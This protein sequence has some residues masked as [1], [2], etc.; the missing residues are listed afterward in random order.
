MNKKNNGSGFNSQKYGDLKQGSEENRI[1]NPIEKNA[2]NV[3]SDRTNNRESNTNQ[4]SNRQAEYTQDEVSS[5]EIMYENTRGQQNLN[6]RTDMQRNNLQR[7]S[8][9]RS[10]DRGSFD[11]SGERSNDRSN[12]RNVD[13]NI[14]RNN[15]G[16]GGQRNNT[17]S[18]NSHSSNT[19]YSN[20]YDQRNQTQALKYGLKTSASVQNSY[21]T[22]QTYMPEEYNHFFQRQ[23]ERLEQI[24][25][26]KVDKDKVH[27]LPL[28]GIGE[29][30]MNSLLYHYLGRWIMIDCGNSFDKLYKNVSHVVIPSVSFVEERLEQFDG[31]FLTHGHEDHIG[32]LPYI[33]E[34]LGCPI[35]GTKFTITLVRRK[36]EERGLPTENLIEVEVG[37]WY[38]FG[39]FEMKW[40]LS[41]HSIPGCCMIALRTPYGSILHTGDWKI[42]DAP[43]INELTDF[44]SIKKLASE[45]LYAVVSDSTN[46]MEAGFNPTEEEVSKSLIKLMTSIQK[47]RIFVTF[48]STNIARLY[49]CIEAG[50]ISGR[51]VGILGRAL[52]RSYEVA[53][54]CGYLKHQDHV[55]FEG[56]E[57]IAPDQVIIA[58]SGSQGEER[59]A[60][61][62]VSLGLHKLIHI[63][64][65]DTVIFSCR[66]IPT[67][68]KEMVAL[69][70]A[71]V[72]RGAKVIT[73]KDALIHSSGH[74]RQKEFE[75]FYNLIKENAVRKVW[76][77]PC[78]GTSMFLERHAAFARERGFLTFS[79]KESFH[80]GKIYQVTQEVKFIDEID[81]E[82]YFLDGNKVVSTDSPII[83]ERQI[84]QEGM[85]S[86]VAVI[87]NGRRLS[88]MHINSYGVD[89]DRAWIESEVK[90]MLVNIFQDLD[91]RTM[92]L[93]KMI[94]NKIANFTRF[95][96]DKQIYVDLHIINESAFK[97][98]QRR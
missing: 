74:A 19:H 56:I 37:K 45:D 32:A 88:Y 82:V 68:A 75:F 12:D 78:H 49:S 20:S 40:I 62:R 14:D 58:C 31:I 72:R 28:G 22:S 73:N 4:Q 43:S 36:F 13:R 95:N 57:D 48:F 53:V 46:I 70:N 89:E 39:T 41:S 67:N 85:I 61:K 30:G 15:H 97:N 50:R 55:I 3:A 18:S 81:H 10:N 6:N 9:N 7:N 80:D 93:N 79:D 90:R 63:D 47:G 86:V 21:E 77:L 84:L 52:Q 5:E 35:Y 66:M 83:Q 23:D 24:R 44:E 42:D 60:L 59:S 29:I 38:K 92:S 76:S 34:R 16:N 11:R 87:S 26:I 54:E 91:S 65:G 33:W 51:K 17:N 8:M 71:L 27:M 25:S 2:G 64:E 1:R 69:E 94:R 96:L 98:N